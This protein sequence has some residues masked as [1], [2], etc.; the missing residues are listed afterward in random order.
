MTSDDPE[1]AVV[2]CVI[3]RFSAR[4]FESSAVGAR[5]AIVEL[6]DVV[7]KLKALD[8]RV[9]RLPDVVGGTGHT[10]RSRLPPGSVLMPAT[11]L[12]DGYGLYPPRIAGAAVEAMARA[13]DAAVE[14]LCYR[15][16]RED[17]RVQQVLRRV[18]AA[19]ARRF[20]IQPRNRAE[21]AVFVERLVHY[22]N[23]W[24]L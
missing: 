6:V 2:A 11:A 7:E 12:H 22:V 4:R 20:G 18:L 19:E 24:M 8:D 10:Y 5:Q 14:R 9:P 1:Y 17:S 21:G 15:D 13:V 23:S 3:V 16:L